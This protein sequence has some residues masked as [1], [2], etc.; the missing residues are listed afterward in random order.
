MEMIAD[1]VVQKYQQS[2]CEQLW[3][4]RGQPKPER[5]E[6]GVRLLRADPVPEGNPQAMGPWEA[7]FA[8]CDATAAKCQAAVQ[9]R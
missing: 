3:K 1:R 6:E 5:E 8:R 2:S 4:E 7:C 9:A